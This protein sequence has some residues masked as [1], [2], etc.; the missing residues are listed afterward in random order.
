MKRFWMACWEFKIQDLVLDRTS[1]P[2]NDNRQYKSKEM[3]EKVRKG[4]KKKNIAWSLNIP[5][6]EGGFGV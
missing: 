5:F 6:V 1:R 3:N 2:Y 4:S